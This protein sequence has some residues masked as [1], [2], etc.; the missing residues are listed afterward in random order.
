MSVGRVRK[1]LSCLGLLGPTITFSV[2]IAVP[3]PSAKLATALS[4][5][6]VGKAKK[7]L[8]AMLPLV[9]RFPWQSCLVMN[10]ICCR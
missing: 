2:L 7:I 4:T 10:P 6:A 5:L 9:L 3:S 1:L 8:G